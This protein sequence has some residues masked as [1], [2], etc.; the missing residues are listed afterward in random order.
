MQVFEGLTE[1]DNYPYKN[2]TDFLGV[3]FDRKFTNPCLQFS[4]YQE[5]K[6][7]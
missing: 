1:E 7:K 6:Q 5:N 4:M 3:L 2:V